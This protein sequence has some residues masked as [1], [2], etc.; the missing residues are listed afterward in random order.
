MRPVQVAAAAILVFAGIA[1]GTQA[2]AVHF[3]ASSAPTIQLVGAPGETVR[4]GCEDTYA[5]T[6]RSN[7][8]AKPPAV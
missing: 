8:N 2:T 5:F 4:V 6:H 1:P 3:A 7:P